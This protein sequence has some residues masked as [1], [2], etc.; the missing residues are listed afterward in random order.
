M[1]TINPKFDAMLLF[2][3]QCRLPTPPPRRNRAVNGVFTVGETGSFQSQLTTMNEYL[4]PLCLLLLLPPVVSGLMVVWN[5]ELV[6]CL[7]RTKI[8]FVFRFVGYSIENL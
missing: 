5:L 7:I 8:T 6:R 4:S 2:L 3:Q 1:S